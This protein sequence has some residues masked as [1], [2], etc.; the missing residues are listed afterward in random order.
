MERSREEGMHT[1]SFSNQ[2]LIGIVLLVIGALLL[3]SNL[4]I[5]PL[6]GWGRWIPSIFILLGIWQLIN[7][8]FRYVTGP[9][10]LIGGGLFFQLASLDILEFETVFQLWPLIL[11]IIGGSILLERVGLDNPLRTGDQDEDTVNILAIFNGPERRISSQ[12]FEGGELTAVVGGI[13]LDLR[14]AAVVDPPATLN[15]FALLGGIDIKAPSD[16]VIQQNVLA[17]L[18]GTEDKRSQLDSTDTRPPDLLVTGFALLGGI[19]I[20]EA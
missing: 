3:L 19:E 13:E 5:A 1:R 8:R 16:W 11:I 2:L 9:F 4:G 6:A 15:V 14:Q 10:I 7:N 12:A 20:K 17:I 18:G